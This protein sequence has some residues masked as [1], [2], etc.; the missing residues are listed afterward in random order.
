MCLTTKV[1]ADNLFTSLPLVQKLRERG[2]YYPGTVRMNR[3]KGY[4]LSSEAELKQQERG[5]S[6]YKV[7]V[8]SGIVAVRWYD[9]RAVDLLSSQ[10]WFPIKSKRWYMCIFFYTTNMMVVNAWL[11]HRTHAQV[12][13]RKTLRLA[14]LQSRLATQLVL[15]KAPVGRPRLIA[16]SPRLSL[17]HHRTAAPREVCLDGQD[18]LPEWGKSRERCK[19]E[20]CPSL[21]YVK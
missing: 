20:G 10:D 12:L 7:E 8:N 9:N 16:S 14:E 3:L 11:R 6:D 15:P 5:S 2:M 18:H 4:S 21:S 17:V 13:K 1:F 19:A